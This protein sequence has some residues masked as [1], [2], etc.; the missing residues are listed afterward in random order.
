MVGAR[1]AE[2]EMASFRSH[3]V[4]VSAVLTLWIVA[5]FVILSPG[6]A[7]AA[8]SRASGAV[9]CQFS[10]AKSVVGVWV[11][12]AGGGSGWAVTPGLPTAAGAPVN[13]SFNVPVGRSYTLTVGCGGTLQAWKYSTV[14]TST[15]SSNVSAVCSLAGS[16][17]LC[18]IAPPVAWAGVVGADFKVKVLA[19]SKDLN[20]DPSYLMAAMAFETG[21]TFSSSI[22]NSSTGATGLIQFMPATAKSL[23]TT[24]AALAAMRPVDQLEYVKRYFQGTASGRRLA[25]LGDVYMCIFWPRAIGQSDEFV[26]FNRTSGAYKPNAGLDLNKDGQVTKLEAASL[27]AAQLTEG[28]KSGKIG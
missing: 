6:V 25:T 5:L 14:T 17:R 23:G 28:T 8:T 13:W 1:R 7:N 24:T 2:V 3:R 20:V 15:T 26:L 12:V 18:D 16:R 27:V 19:I 21:R 9:I 11:E 10:D 22:P 4:S